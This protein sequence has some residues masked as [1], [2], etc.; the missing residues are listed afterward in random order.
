MYFFLLRLGI[1]LN[2]NLDINHKQGEFFKNLLEKGIE[3]VLNKRNSINVF[4]LSFVLLLIEVDFILEE[5]SCKRDILM[6]CDTSYIK[7]IFVLLTK[8]IAFYI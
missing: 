5:Q 6:T 4:N 3:F 2:F 8:V 1:L 7:I